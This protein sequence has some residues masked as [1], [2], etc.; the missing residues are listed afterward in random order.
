MKHFTMTCMFIMFLV[1]K[2][3]LVAQFQM[4]CSTLNL[5]MKQRKLLK[6]IR[7]VDMY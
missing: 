6:Y 5:L 4:G 3:L 7:L 1:G 2:N